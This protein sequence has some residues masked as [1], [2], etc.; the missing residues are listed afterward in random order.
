MKAS[1]KTTQSRREFVLN[2]SKIGL[3][4][5]FL[6]LCPRRQLLGEESEEKPVPDPKK[7]NYC[8]YVCEVDCAMKLVGESGDIE[9]KKEVYEKWKI[10]EN[11]GI[12]FDPDQVFCNGCKTDEE[13]L[14][15]LVSHCSIRKCA[16]NKNLDGC[17]QCD[18]LTACSE[19]LWKRF[20]GFHK[21]V[22]DMQNR[23]LEA[24]TASG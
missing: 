23:Y 24:Q 19:T 15:V 4:C 11:H 1:P 12:E 3:A 8:G 5:G 22:I 9:K 21:M 13:E 7:M 17:I 6:S 20:P 16:I 10:K 2:S 14:G 18:E